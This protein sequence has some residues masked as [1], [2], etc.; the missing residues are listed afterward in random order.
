MAD[1]SRDHMG[2]KRQG[3]KGKESRREGGREDTGRET[4]VQTIHSILLPIYQI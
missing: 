1:Q 4:D 3:E 2:G